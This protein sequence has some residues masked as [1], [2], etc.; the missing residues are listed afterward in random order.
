M[1]LV[2]GMVHTRWR[3]VEGI[4]SGWA[5]QGGWEVRT[6][7]VVQFCWALPGVLGDIL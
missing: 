3:G 6:W 1:L 2:E 5:S 7:A 4:V